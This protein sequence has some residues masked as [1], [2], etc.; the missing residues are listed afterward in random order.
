MKA[1]ILVAVV[2]VPALLLIIY[3]L[4]PVATVILVAG[5]CVISVHELLTGTGL[6]KDK[7]LI[8]LSMLMAAAIPFWSYYS[9]SS[10]LVLWGLFVWFALLFAVALHRH[11]TVQISELFA[12]FFAAVM[13]PLFMSALVRIRRMEFGEYYILIP[14]AIAFVADG[15]AYFTGTFL[16][17]H[18]MAPQ[19]SPKKT[20]EG[21][22]G[23]ALTA[24]LAMLIYCAVCQYGF[25]RQPVY[26]YA[27]L[28]ALV[29][30]V[31]D[32]EGDL[33]F[34]LIKRQTGIKD[35][36]KLLPGH[37]GILDRF[38]SMIFVAPL[39]ELLLQV[40][41]LFEA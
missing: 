3:A 18:K 10:R 26:L 11:Q 8:A 35:Y 36:G 17:K 9:Q 19:L 40:L 6:V 27:V 1:R 21:V 2:C 16:G 38:D 24:V 14:I 37:G 12:S 30:S 33:A 15:G 32:Y 31:L 28:Y 25:G 39:T 13:I 41:P 29:G 20:W 22:F 34:S 4:P 7:I 5:L 23:G